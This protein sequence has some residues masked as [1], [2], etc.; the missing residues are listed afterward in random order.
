MSYTRANRPEF[1]I[2]RSK[3]ASQVRL[4]KSAEGVW[5]D[6]GGK[7]GSGLRKYL[8]DGGGGGRFTSREEFDASYSPGER[9]S[10]ALDVFLSAHL[11]E[12]F[13]KKFAEAFNAQDW[14]ETREVAWKIVSELAGTYRLVTGRVLQGAEAIKEL[15]ED[16]KQGE[17]HF[18]LGKEGEI[19]TNRRRS[20]SNAVRLS[21]AAAVIEVCDGTLWSRTDLSDAR[22][23]KVIRE[24][25]RATNI[26][27]KT[28][29]THYRLL[30][31]NP[32]ALE[33]P[34]ELNGFR[35]TADI[36][37]KSYNEPTWAQHHE[38]LSLLRNTARL[39]V[40]RRK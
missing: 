34:D 12:R 21:G 8:P 11:L 17:R 5:E 24:T 38:M 6:R 19:F 31:E 25:A 13:D 26:D 35:I 9:S 3:Q 10:I 40:G 30:T 37:R 22:L 14:S 16:T 27:K 36:L 18:L 32:A 20:L 2:G 29:L 15:L 1:T 28:L 23:K 4:E 39:T 33:N 7:A